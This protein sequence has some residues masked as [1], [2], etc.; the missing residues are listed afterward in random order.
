MKK[1]IA[2]MLCAFMLLGCVSAVA[3]ANEKTVLGV[4]EMKGAF[5][6]ECN[7]PEGYSLETFIANPDCFLGLLTSDDADKP[8]VGISIAFS[9]I[10]ADVERLND[11]D[12]DSLA[13]IEE[14][15][16]AED[17]VDITYM[18]TAYGTKLM[19]VREISEGMDYIDFYTIYKGYEVEVVLTYGAEFAEKSITEEQVQMVVDFLSDMDFV[20]VA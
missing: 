1:I 12:A 10:Y 5:R 2:V 17:E 7:I 18:E 8:R 16:T 11:L 19:V 13:G 4:V 6:L 14:S 3:E 20:P 9:E 15:F